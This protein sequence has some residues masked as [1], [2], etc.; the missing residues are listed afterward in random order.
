[1]PRLFDKI[2]PPGL[3]TQPQNVDELY[4]GVD[5]LSTRLHKMKILGPK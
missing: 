5:C 4:Y 1:M 2:L 3:S